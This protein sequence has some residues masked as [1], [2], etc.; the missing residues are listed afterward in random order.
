M[1]L[2]GVTDS[3]ESGDTATGTALVVGVAASVMGVAVS[4][5]L[6]ADVRGVASDD[7]EFTGDAAA[8]LMGVTEITELAVGVA[9]LV[10][11][12]AVVTTN[13]DATLAL[14]VGVAVV[15]ELLIGRISVVQIGGTTVAIEVGGATVA[16]VKVREVVV[17]IKEMGGATI[18]TVEMGGATVVW[19]NRAVV[20]MS[21]DVSVAAA[22]VMGRASLFQKSSSSLL[23][24]SWDIDRSCDAGK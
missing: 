21:D 4:L 6:T 19:V 15:V 17:T 3:L 9:T 18:A 24:T 22:V 11:G 5:E 8:L 2:M 20:D 16:L 12:V 7:L 10:V 14:V 1:P 13:N 23:T